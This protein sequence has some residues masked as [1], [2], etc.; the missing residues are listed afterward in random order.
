[1]KIQK[2]LK[3]K[4]EK[5]LEKNEKCTLWLLKNIKLWKSQLAYMKSDSKH[6]LDEEGKV[7][8]VGLIYSACDL[9]INDFIWVEFSTNRQLY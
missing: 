6:S 7:Q 4:G 9:E 2:K 8:G 3:I 5:T 1:M